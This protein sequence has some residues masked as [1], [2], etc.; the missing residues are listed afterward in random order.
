MAAT[1]SG[2]R[3]SAD[4]G[5]TWSI[6]KSGGQELAGTSTEVKIGPDG[7]IAASVNN[8]LYVSNGSA[9]GFELRSSGDAAHGLPAT[10][11]GR[12]Q[13]AFAHSEASTL[14]AMM[15]A[16]GTVTGYYRGQLNGI[17]VSKDKGATWR[18]VGPG[19]SAIFNVFG[20]STTLNYGEYG[21]TI[22]V[23]PTNP[24]KIYVG[25]IFAWEGTKIQETGFFQWQ[26]RANVGMVAQ[27][28]HSLVINPNDVQ[29]VYFT[30]DFGV[31]VTKNNFETVQSL[32]RN[33]KTSMFY[34]VA[35]DDQGR[36]FG[37][38]Q[39]YGV[40]YLDRKGNTI[41]TASPLNFA[42]VGGSVDASLVNPAALFYSTIGGVLTR[43]P[44]YGASEST[45]FIYG[46]EIVN[47]N[48]ANFITPFRLWE[49]FN[50]QY[51]R[52]SVWYK[53]T[54]SHNAGDAVIVYSK[55][56]GFPFRY[57]LANNISQGDSIRVKDVVSSIMFVGSTNAVY[58]S[59]RILDFSGLPAW[60]K[61][62]AF[63]LI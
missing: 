2:L 49:S 54:K 31:G 46:K 13:V 27:I 7:S 4:G 29:N 1:N 12:I 23:S 24:D 51:S 32:N 55:N 10:G 25:G 15:I 3:Y 33:Y 19:A 36:V 42:F 53:A 5:Q 11:I 61:I 47:N 9:D 30:S 8:L 14:Y 35:A 40:V 52:D 44:D 22:V 26:P 41:E 60:D 34:T 37:G 45:D 21:G 59:R 38:T 57:N 62:S 58:M 50:N 43:T 17:Y 48:T 16:D 20:N 56:N 63:F 28:L 6:A 18:V 39:G